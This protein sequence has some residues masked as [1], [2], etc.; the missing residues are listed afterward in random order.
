[1]QKQIARTCGADVVQRGG[2]V[3][4][5]IG[6]SEVNGRDQRNLAAARNKLWVGHTLYVLK[7]EYTGK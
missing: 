5:P 4:V 1:M 7:T 6:T 2:H 3:G